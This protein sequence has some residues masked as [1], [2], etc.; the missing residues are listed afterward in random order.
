MFHL[1]L[2]ARRTEEAPGAIEQE[3]SKTWFFFMLSVRTRT[4]KSGLSFSLHVAMIII[5]TSR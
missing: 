5:S 1:A 4:H 2:G 3:Y